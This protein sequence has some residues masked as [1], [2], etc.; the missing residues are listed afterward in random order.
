[1]FSR[2]LVAIDGGDSARDAVELAIRLAG[3][4]RARIGFVH[5]LLSPMAYVSEAALLRD[6]L[7]A[8]ARQYAKALF[9][10]AMER[11]PRGMP[12]DE[13]MPEGDP[14]E[15]IIATARSW[16]ADLI[17]VGTHGAGRVGSFLL[18]STAQAVI[19]KSGCPVLV[20]KQGVG[21]TRMASLVA[22]SVTIPE[23]PP[24]N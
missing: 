19:R 5:V 10:E 3:E 18:G 1:M 11:L 17:V 20:V 7:H 14:S 2:I 24:S 8:H 21:T 16:G 13:F 12:A 4:Q 23:P 22:D 15:E 6:Q 9:H